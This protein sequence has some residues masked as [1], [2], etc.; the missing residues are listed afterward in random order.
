MA[1]KDRAD[2]G[3][4]SGRNTSRLRENWKPFTARRASAQGLS[5]IT[6]T[7]TMLRRERRRNGSKSR[8]PSAFDATHG[9]RWSAREPVADKD[10]GGGSRGFYNFLLRFNRGT[11]ISGG[12]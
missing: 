8:A 6:S 4:R 9:P 7:K 5:F 11:R 2:P 10:A 1:Q 12:P 3:V